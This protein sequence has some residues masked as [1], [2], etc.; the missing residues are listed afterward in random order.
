MASRQL[1]APL[2]D[3]DPPLD[4]DHDEATKPPLPPLPPPARR[5]LGFLVWARHELLGF[6]VLV[7]VGVTLGL[8][9]PTASQPLQES[10]YAALSNVFGWVYFLAWTVSFY[11][12]LWVNRQQQTARGLSLDFMLLNLL[13]FLCY[14]CFA[15]SFY[16]VPSIQQAYRDRHE[17]KD[18]K[19]TIQD[20]F[21]AVHAAAITWFTTLQMF[22][23][24]GFHDTRRRLSRPI[25][26]VL[27]LL[28]AAI[29]VAVAVAAARGQ[30]GNW[31][32]LLYFVSYIKIFISTIKGVPQ[33][34]FNYRRKSTVGW[35]IHNILCDFT[36]GLFSV[37][38]LVLDCA[39]EDDWGGISGDPLKF[40]LGLISMGLDVVFFVQHFVLY[41][42]PTSLSVAAADR[43]RRRDSGR[44]VIK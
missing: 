7:L 4:H 22:Y 30:P 6:A 40:S 19:V 33:A 42:P 44:G 41:R 9:L 18:N 27:V 2:L 36:G 20:L 37:L 5:C 23:L 32:D 39:V 15:L 34:Y 12:Q 17:G 21:F 28:L 14:S 13:G 25:T 11:P 16:T 43:E 35:S 24:D 31:L 29:L 10:G 8:S 3:R 1:Q 26:V 38:Q